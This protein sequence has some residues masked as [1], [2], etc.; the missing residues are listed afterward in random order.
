MWIWENWNHP[1]RTR[2]SRTSWKPSAF[3]LSWCEKKHFCCKLT[4]Y[5]CWKLWLE[6]SWW[7]FTKDS[8][9]LNCSGLLCGEW[10]VGRSMGSSAE[11]IIKVHWES[12]I[13]SASLC[14]LMGSPPVLLAPWVSEYSASS[15]T[16]WGMLRLPPCPPEPF[17]L[18]L[19]L[20]PLCC[21]MMLGSSL[22]TRRPG[23]GGRW[24]ISTRHSPQSCLCPFEESPGANACYLRL[25]HRSLNRW[26]WQLNSGDDASSVY[27]CLDPRPRVVCFLFRN[28]R[29]ICFSSPFLTQDKWNLR[30]CHSPTPPRV[31]Q[32]YGNSSKQ[33]TIVF[34]KLKTGLWVGGSLKER[35]ETPPLQIL[36]FS[37]LSAVVGGRGVEVAGWRKGCVDGDGLLWNPYAPGVMK[38]KKK[39]SRA[40]FFL[41]FFK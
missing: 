19:A 18:M 7:R 16:G 36:E 14:I 3:C 23:A 11:L 20:Q 26:P 30:V 17:H 34:Q 5:Y 22:P 9:G 1:R 21:M 41:A 6:W 25:A 32:P 33:T 24:L 13:S 31:A 10:G 8:W 4:D 28:L 37:S 29:D 12:G 38:Q 40:W 27:Q 2:S 15:L 39:I 35:E